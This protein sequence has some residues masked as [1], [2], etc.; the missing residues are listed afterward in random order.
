MYLFFSLLLSQH[1]SLSLFI[2]HINGLHFIDVSS[3]ETSRFDEWVVKQIQD[4]QL[5]QR[6]SSTMQ[7]TTTASQFKQTLETDGK[8]VHSGALTDDLLM[9]RNNLVTKLGG[10]FF[11]QP[12][13]PQFPADKAKEKSKATELYAELKS[14]STVELLKRL[15]PT[16]STQDYVTTVMIKLFTSRQLF[17][18]SKSPHSSVF[19][20][21]KPSVANFN[22]DPDHLA[23]VHPSFGTR[24]PDGVWYTPDQRGENAIVLLYDVKQMSKS[25]VFDDSDQGHVFD[26]ALKL[27]QM[28]NPLRLGIIF[29][30]TDGA[31]FQ[32]FR[33]MR[34]N[35]GRDNVFD[36]T[37]IIRGVVGWQVYI[38]ILCSFGRL[39]I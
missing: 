31:N 5:N 23:Y 19:N 26:M 10:E 30:L 14:L 37:N 13:V 20:I 11:F 33:L 6:Q 29:F 34:H 35:S 27:L 9:K 17:M 4:L 39:I 21:S 25:G 32:F 18:K 2:V 15:R 3:E 28:Q 12:G 7:G 38:S 22:V 1:F 8:Y 16:E 36:Y 24:R